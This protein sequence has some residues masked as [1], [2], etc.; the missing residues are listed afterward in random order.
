MQAVPIL[1]GRAGSPPGQ[2]KNSGD[3]PSPKG[4]RGLLDLAA[5][6]PVGSLW[7]VTRSFSTYRRSADKVVVTSQRAFQGE[8]RAGDG[9][10]SAA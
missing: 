6:P 4:E 3:R 2:E 10:L 8:R 1:A 7:A 9:R 5:Q